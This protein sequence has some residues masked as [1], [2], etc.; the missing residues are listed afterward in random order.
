[1]QKKKIYTPTKI[2]KIKEQI[3]IGKDV[4]KLE[5]SLIAGRIV[6]WCNHF[7]KQFDSSQKVK[8]HLMIQISLL[9]ICPRGIRA[10]V[11]VKT[12]IQ[13]SHSSIIYNS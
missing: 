1:M 5:P 9:N 7:R 2:T 13:K 12:Y 10:Y 11:H 8:H 4:E 6:M 3:N